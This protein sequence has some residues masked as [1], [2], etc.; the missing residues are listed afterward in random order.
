MKG[1]YCKFLYLICGQL[2]IRK[3]LRIKNLF[4]RNRRDDP[5]NWLYKY[6]DIKLNVLFEYNSVS[7][8]CEIQFMLSFY[9]TAKTLGHGL[10]EIERNYEF[11]MFFACFI[12]G[13]CGY[14]LV[15]W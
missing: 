4:S 14:N 6:G 9:N 8:I 13:E 7:M 5:S 11:G 2:G 1:V 3:I 15:I 12:L 10:Y